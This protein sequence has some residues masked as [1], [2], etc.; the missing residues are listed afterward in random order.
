MDEKLTENQQR[1]LECIKANPSASIA[2]IAELTGVNRTTVQMAVR[3]MEERKII[4]TIES[5][6]KIL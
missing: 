3:T 1:I 4:T 6:R 2:E 5:F